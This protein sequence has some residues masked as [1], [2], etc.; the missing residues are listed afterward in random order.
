MGSK[1]D[2][3][4]SNSEARETASAGVLMRPEIRRSWRRSSLSGVD[5]ERGS[6][7]QPS[8]DVNLDTELHI[9]AAPVLDTLEDQL[10]VPA[11]IVLSDA[12]GRFIRFWARDERPTPARENRRLSRSGCR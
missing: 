8:L 12:A 2:H 1:P 4:W 11:L 6:L 5:R 3:H 9:A 10:G 7:V